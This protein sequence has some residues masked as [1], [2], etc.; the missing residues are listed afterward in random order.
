M[1]TPEWNDKLMPQ[2]RAYKLTG[3]LPLR[4]VQAKGI[5]GAHYTGQVI[6]GPD[7]HEEAVIESNDPKDALFLECTECGHHV[8]VVDKTFTLDWLVS[9]VL[10]HK[11]LYHDQALSAVGGGNG[12]V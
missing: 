8:G 6:V 2:A 4:V 7:G 11:V 10:T 9:K 12:E 3:D 1:G 5:T